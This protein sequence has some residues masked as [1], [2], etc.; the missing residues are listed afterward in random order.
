MEDNFIIRALKQMQYDFIIE[1][2]SLQSVYQ[3]CEEFDKYIFEEI[4]KD[5]ENYK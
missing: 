1:K 4:K 3:F 2:L 5:I